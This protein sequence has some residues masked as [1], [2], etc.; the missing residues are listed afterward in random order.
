[1]LPGVWT[2]LLLSGVS[3][4]W[5]PIDMLGLLILEVIAGA[6]IGPPVMPALP[7]FIPEVMLGLEPAVRLAGVG[8]DAL[9]GVRMGLL[10]GDNEP[11]IGM[12]PAGPI[13]PIWALGSELDLASLAGGC[14]AEIPWGDIGPNDP[15]G[16]AP[17]GEYEPDILALLC[18]ILAALAW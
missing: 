18:S 2:M 15:G 1:M 8:V 12:A 9:N 5:V 14:V 11:C 10:S 17:P 3:Q 16:P 4:L 6:L 7:G 13:G